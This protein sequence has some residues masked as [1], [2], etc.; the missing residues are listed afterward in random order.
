MITES[1]NYHPMGPFILA[2]FAFTAV[3]SLFPGNVR[4]RLLRYMRNRAAVFNALYLTF[5]IAF[6]GFGTVRAL[7]HYG[8]GWLDR[9]L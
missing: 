2:L 5:V 3:Q 1:W 4:E 8:A 9:L 6:V 7:L